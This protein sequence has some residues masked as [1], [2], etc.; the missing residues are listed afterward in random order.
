MREEG[1]RL[2]QTVLGLVPKEQ[3]GF[4][5]SH[6]HLFLAGGQPAAVNP[7]L[8]MDDYERSI[9]ELTLFK[10]AGG[11]SLVDAQPLGC[12][13]ME[14]YLAAAS[15]ECG[16]NIVASTGFH[17]LAFYPEHHWVH[18]FTEDQL[19]EVFIKELTE[20]MFVN[21]EHSP[22]IESVP[23]KA[24]NIKAAYDA[25]RQVDSDKKWFKAAAYACLETGFPI[26]CH[27]ESTAQG[28]EIA[29]F[30]LKLGVSP[31]RLIICHV[32]RTLDDLH[33]HRELASIGVYLEYDTIGR[34]KYH[35]DEEEAEL[36]MMMEEAGLTSRILI[37]LDTTRARMKSYGGAI[38]LDYIQNRFIP[39]LK[40][41]GLNHNTIRQITIENP[42]EAFSNN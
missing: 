7:A 39:L 25:D 1:V 13:R 21:T 31:Q 8:R 27:V 17:K 42:S 12:G 11:Q 37:G 29:E 36:I 41:Y 32:D 20:G 26:M 23:Y 34:F 9:R 3:F 19:I 6:E 14:K 15:K 5:H 4:C 24:G 40:R 38:G 30:F 16:I 2:I 18:T 10:H 28:V 22:P 33:L 35:T